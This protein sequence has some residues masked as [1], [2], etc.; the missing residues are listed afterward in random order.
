MALNKFNG[1]ES[2]LLVTAL[3][4]QCEEACDDIKRMEDEGK[5]PMFTV[6]YINREHEQLINIIK[7]HTKKP[8]KHG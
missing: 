1:R 2:Y 5:N 6:G 3:Q 7:S 4:N 8:R